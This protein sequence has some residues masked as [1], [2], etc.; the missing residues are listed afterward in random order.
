MNSIFIGWVRTLKLGRRST[1]PQVVIDYSTNHRKPGVHFQAFVVD[2]GSSTSCLR[3]NPYRGTH[4]SADYL[5]M[6]MDLLAQFKEEN[7]KAKADGTAFERAD[8]LEKGLKP[9]DQAPAPNFED[10]AMQMQNFL[11]QSS[12]ITDNTKQI[13]KLTNELD[14]LHK[15]ALTTAS[16]EESGETSAKIEI[17]SAKINQHSNK[18]RNLLQTIQR[19]NEQLQEIAPPGSGHMRMREQKHRAL[20]TAFLNASKKLQKLQQNYRDKYRQQLER[21]YKI[22]NP[23]ATA[24]EIFAITSD[25]TGARAKIFAVSVKEDQ[26]K[27]LAQMKDRFQDV[28]TIEKSILELHQLFLDLQTIVVEQGDM[29]NRVEFNVDKTAGY[30]D[31]AAQDMKLAVEYQKSI[32]KKKWILVIIAMVG[33]VIL[34]LIVL[35]L[36]RPRRFYP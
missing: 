24:E 7:Q 27:T 17:V 16:A 25:E 18:N 1:N 22:V 2:V 6:G 34:I 3:V 8:Q 15:L 20:A 32:W 29:L 4:S 35:Y 14:R 13:E 33:I 5:L 31:N 26:K 23:H 36:I 21:Q 10:D 9:G 28:R 30:T 12:E 11:Q 19:E